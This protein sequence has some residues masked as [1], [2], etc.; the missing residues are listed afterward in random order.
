MCLDTIGLYFSFRSM[1]WGFLITCEI[2]QSMSV[3][4]DNAKAGWNSFIILYF[5]PLNCLLLVWRSCFRNSSF[6]LIAMV[7]T[8]CLLRQVTPFL[9]RSSSCHKNINFDSKCLIES[10]QKKHGAPSGEGVRAETHCA[11]PDFPRLSPWTLVCFWRCPW[12]RNST[13]LSPLPPGT[14]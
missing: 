11:S 7:V 9:Q 12:L 10:P 3:S 1:C 13:P 5:L 6:W 2:L 8:C 14:Q 4:A